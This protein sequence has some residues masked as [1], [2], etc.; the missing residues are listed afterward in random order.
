MWPDGF[1]ATRYHSLVVDRSSC[2]DSLEIS[3]ETAD[4]VIMGLRHREF[5][6]EGIQFHPESIMTDAGQ[7]LVDNWL[8]RAGA[9]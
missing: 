7:A 9:C 1:T 4:G 6:I 3:A 5:E 2:P 8:T